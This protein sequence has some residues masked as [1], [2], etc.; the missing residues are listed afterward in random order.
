MRNRKKLFA[1]TGGFDGADTNLIGHA[2]GRKKAPT[3]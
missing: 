1:Y 3:H 2:F